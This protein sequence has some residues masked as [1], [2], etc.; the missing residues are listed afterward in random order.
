M[1]VEILNSEKIIK[2]DCVD[3]REG[4]PELQPGVRT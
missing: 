3:T 2:F 4:L 1:A